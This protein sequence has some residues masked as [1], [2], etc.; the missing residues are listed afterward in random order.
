MLKRIVKIKQ[1]LEE[2]SNIYT[3]A[4]EVTSEDSETEETTGTKT[5]ELYLNGELV[6]EI[7]P[8]ESIMNDMLYVGVG[9]GTD[10]KSLE[11]EIQ[12]VITLEPL[13]KW[14]FNVDK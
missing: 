7:N 6:T 10:S 1:K 3:A 12:S 13:D 14:E 9:A 2:I 5:L 4:E 8:K 11:V